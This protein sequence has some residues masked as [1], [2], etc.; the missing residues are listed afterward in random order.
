MKYLYLFLTLFA[1]FA[2][3][4]ES[5][6]TVK[7]IVPGDAL[8]WEIEEVVMTLSLGQDSPV[9][10]EIYS[11]GFDP[12]DYRAA[13]DGREE[14]G[15][16]RYG[17]TP[18]VGA[19]VLEDGDT[20]AE[21]RYEVEQ[22][23]WET[24]FE[25]TLE[26]GAYTL[27]SRFTGLGKNAFII[28]VTTP[29][30]SVSSLRFAEGV[31]LFDVRGGEWTQAFQAKLPREG[32]PARYALYDGDGAGELEAK[33]VMA[34]GSER[35][36]PVS[37]DLAWQVW[38]FDEA[39]TYTVYLR[40]P[41]GAYQYS[42]TVATKTLYPEPVVAEVVD[43]A[44]NPLDIP[45]RI[46]G[47]SERTVTL[48]VPGEYR[49]VDIETDGARG[50]GTRVDFG[51]GG[52]QVRYVLEQTTGTELEPEPDP[53][54]VTPE[55]ITPQP[56]PTPEPEAQAAVMLTRDLDLDE[57][58]PGEV[59]TV[60]LT[61]SHDSDES[62]SYTLSDLPPE[63]LEPLE[64]PLFE[65]TLAAG[66]A[67]THTYEA[68]V[69]FG[70]EETGEF[71]ARLTSSVGDVAAPDTLTRRL[72]LVEKRAETETALEGQE[73][74]FT[75]RVTN[76]LGR[77]VS[78]ELR[79]SPQQGLGL[80]G[81]L[82][83]PVTL[84]A[85]ESKTFEF[86][87]TPGRTGTLDNQASVFIG[88]TPAGF[89]AGARLDVK[90][91]LT[92]ER[93]SLVTLP[94]SVQVEGRTLQ[95]V[96]DANGGRLLVRHR[97]PAGAAY[98]AGSS[99]LGGNPTPDP[100]TR[101]VDEGGETLTYL[102]W[103]L[104]YMRA[105]A[106]RYTLT[107]QESLDALA[108]PSLTLKFGN[109]DLF[110]EGEVPFEEVGDARDTA[111]PTERDGLI[112]EPL[113]GTV[114]RTT[115]AATVIIQ[116][117]LSTEVEVL[118]N[119]A[120]VA[121]DAL[122][123]RVVDE[124][125]GTLRLEYFGVPL[126]V[127]RN[128][129]EVALGGARDQVEVFRAGNPEAL[130]IVPSVLEADG[131]TPVAF[132][133]RASDEFGVTNGFGAVTLQTDLEPLE[134]DAFPGESGYQVLLED[135]VATVR[136]EPVLTAQEA[137]LTARFNDLET[138]ETFYLGGADEPLYLYQ[139]SVSVHL[140]RGELSYNGVA[141]G[142]AE[143]P[144]GSGTLQGALDTGGDI[145]E[146]DDPSGRFPL[147]GSGNDAQPALRSDDLVAARYDD[148]TFSVGYYADGLGVPGLDGVASGTALQGEVRT[149][150]AG[151]DLVGRA[152]A[153][154]LPKG[155]LT[156]AI[157]PDGTRRY[158][159]STAP[160]RS[161]SETVT[162]RTG[163]QERVL[164]R[165]EDYTLND[166][167]G[168]LT[169]SKPLFPTDVN[170]VETH[171]E[172]TYA[173]T[174]SPRETLAAGAGVSYQTGDWAFGA[175]LVS[176]EGVH[177]GAYADYAGA[178]SS[179]SV[180]YRYDE[181]LRAQLGVS[182]TL[183]QGV[184]DASANINYTDA[185]QGQARVA[186]SF[187]EGQRAVVEHSARG[188]RNQTNALYELDVDALT[189]GL[190]TGYLW[191]AQTF[192]AVARVGYRAGRAN[193]QLAHTQPFGD[194]DPISDFRVSYQI[195]ENLAA[196]L[197]INYTWGGELI[198]TV[199]LVQD[200]G[201][202]NLSVSYQLPGADGRGN[203]A[204]FGIETP[205]PLSDA[206][207]LD[208]S[209]NVDQDFNGGNTL[210]SAG[211]GARYSKGDF[212]ATASSEVSYDSAQD[213]PFKITFRGGASGQLDHQQVLSFDATYQLTSE[214]EGE[215]TA[216]YALRSR[217]LTLST[218]HTL[219]TGGEEGS[220]LEG[221]LAPTLHPSKGW[222]LR[223]GF[224]YRVPLWNDRRS[225]FLASLGGHYYLTD[226]AGV[227]GSV[228]HEWQPAASSS[229]T[230]FS[231]E[232]SLRVIDDLWLALGYTFEGFDG[233][234]EDTRSG[235]HLRFELLGGGQ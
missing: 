232:G 85:N 106:L 97:V 209:A 34:D 91:V 7:G 98:E 77:T 82:V 79:E 75:V 61:V 157:I 134:A 41:K 189:F 50:E 92:P 83:I 159:L 217:Y 156:E 229:A 65:G 233:L 186:Y 226:D 174:D 48:E 213:D 158:T 135:G 234:N 2:L 121:N 47:Y 194:A 33:V 133:I 70:A 119:G 193:F 63:W 114:Y 201:R 183:T 184:L 140:T 171:I 199:A 144:L 115:D 67:V 132:K 66:D 180:T 145:A 205:L 129:V 26:K 64:P 166:V 200:L 38:E 111:A 227:G 30:P 25:G 40:Q 146:Q 96:E 147:T 58:L 155:Q 59:V 109:R 17:D 176:L 81:D 71:T 122:G 60:S 99:R 153:S 49:L 150:F 8:G 196:D 94:F 5:N 139:G 107:H 230:A 173:P 116:G 36:L 192:S 151:G 118:L 103:E 57:V 131:V 31:E 164:E 152:F 6:N 167:T 39:G 228:Y 177:F 43:T 16:E 149:D 161:N 22:H 141:R 9:K 93:T 84:E 20:I 95:E 35:S 76:P 15:D 56:E 224:A 221:E 28:R 181:D 128:V 214:A 102:Y 123:K 190:G 222:Q 80:E 23:E 154:L 62:V 235:L 188:D 202:G 52:G 89:P 185:L 1:S 73:T 148:D 37:E 18:L 78:F 215:F 32:V 206:W 195:D 104:P 11:P 72:I 212:V 68:S 219:E 142:Y 24:L 160:I 204:R 74:R 55:P 126:E 42:N 117:P 198:G 138:Q 203:R 178:G 172:V 197:G 223:P 3:A 13:L 220:E 124:Q 143:M 69:R 27:R 90:P 179:F 105:G 108:E 163:A 14:L 113:P 216:A 53:E 4:D 112:R 169:L 44:G 19:F 210:A 12:D 162:V 21:R 87:A 191:E 29:D 51:F 120:P 136:L 54:P 127:G 225:T 168:A 208:L 231:V 211:A 175:G 137:S 45:V 110:L 218:Y 187:S 182:G 207:S 46:T 88:Q 101:T 125:N 170:G 130:E 86:V 165:L 100:L 10:L